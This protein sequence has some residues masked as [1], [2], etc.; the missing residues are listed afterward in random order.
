LVTQ[1]R[2]L[3][4]K[5]DLAHHRQFQSASPLNDDER[6]A[7][8]VGKLIATNVRKG[9]VA[10]YSNYRGIYCT[11][12]DFRGGTFPHG[13]D[14]TGAVLDGSNFSGARLEAAV[15]DN[16]ELAGT[17]FVEADLRQAKFRS[18]HRPLRNADDV[19]DGPALPGRTMYLDHVA[20]ALDLNP[21]VGIRMPN[22][23]CANLA[24]ANFDYHSLFPGV[25]Q[26][27]RSYTKGDEGKL[28]WYQ[29]VSVYYKDILR[30]RP[31]IDFL[32]AQISP[33]KFLKADITGAHFEN[34]RFFTFAN[35]QDDKWFS[36][37]YMSDSHRVRVGDFDVAQGHM[38]SRAFL[39]SQEPPQ[40]P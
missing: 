9:V 29:N 12:C 23:S 33:P 22:F 36:G 17:K 5:A 32:V 6:A 19:D 15:F 4:A 31:S 40:R 20:S 34:V 28:G 37:G 38:A 30:R 10:D 11:E 14:F 13:A 7:R 16:A 25:I 21:V 39:D 8:T 1:S 2:A 27:Y 18:Q 24:D 26:V 3:L 35:S